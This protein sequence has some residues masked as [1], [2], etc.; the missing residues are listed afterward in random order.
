M[1]MSK[2]VTVYSTPTC[3]FCHLAKD[4]FQEHNIPF[5]EYDVAMDADR[6]M[7]MRERTG[8][9]GVPVIMIDQDI[10]VGFDEQKIR[11]LLGI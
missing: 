6:R 11:T 4:F 3:H 10:I 2:T 5:T 8:Q 1:S 9:L 7:E